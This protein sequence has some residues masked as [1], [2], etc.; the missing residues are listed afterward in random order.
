MIQLKKQVTVGIEMRDGQ[1]G[2]LQRVWR[3][4]ERLVTCGDLLKE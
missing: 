3:A 1:G 2:G 4:R